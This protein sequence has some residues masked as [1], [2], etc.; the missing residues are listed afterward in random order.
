MDVLT[1]I[2]FFVYS[3]GLGFSA[4]SFVRNAD[5][6]LE[7]NLMRVGVGFSLITFVG[8]LLNLLRI[9]VHWWAILIFSMAYPVFYLVKNRESIA[10]EKIKVR[11]TR[12]DISIILMLIIFIVNLYIYTSGAFAYPYLEDDDPWSHSFGVKYFA[13]EKSA[14]SDHIRYMDP[15]PPA[16]DML[17]GTLLQTNN[18]IYWTLKFFNALIISLSVIFFYFF[19]REF[20]DNRKKA[21]FAAF[22]LA[23]IPCYLSHFIW[24]IALTMPLFFVSFY[25]TERIKKDKKWFI[26]AGLVMVT[27]LTSS[28]THSVYFGLFFVLYIITKIIALRKIPLWES[29]AGLLGLGLSFVLWWLPMIIKHGMDGVLRGI[30]LQGQSVLNVAGT[31]D[32]AYS[33]GDF[34]FAKTQNMINNPIGIG[35]VL[36]ILTFIGLVVIALKY[37]NMLKKENNWM[38]ITLV[39]F[40]FTLYAVNSA[41]MPIKI[42]PFRTWVLFAIPLCIIAAEGTMLLLNL[43]RRAVVLKYI[44]FIGILVGVIL[45]SGYQK[46][47]V[48]TSQ[49]HPGGFWASSEEIAGYLWLKDNIPKDSTVFTFDNDAPIIGMDMMTCFWCEDVRE[50]KKIGFN[51]SAEKNYN[52]LKEKG[53]EYIVIDSETVRKFGTERTNKKINEIVSINKF[54]VIYNKPGLILFKVL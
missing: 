15:Y 46:Y 10:F 40:I 22:F 9:P 52:W 20:T 3:W 11:I 34:I 45:T 16:Y 18:S 43:F 27:T 17:M 44:L 31:A 24:G 33:L 5:N 19:V 26:V 50:Y 51:L 48:N 42:S 38:I 2:L 1:I 53:Y 49:W 29:A 37:K 6:F 12:Y 13:V 7:R 39:W 14:F 54:Q 41:N 8:F 23:A 28:T 47:A 35:I 32:R 25:A 36:S 4:T 30:G 21:L